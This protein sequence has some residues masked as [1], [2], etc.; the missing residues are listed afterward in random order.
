MILLSSMHPYNVNV[1]HMQV[2]YD[3]HDHNSSVW[4][5]S[6]VPLELGPRYQNLLI[7]YWSIRLRQSKHNH[8][9]RSTRRLIEYTIYQTRVNAATCMPVMP[10]S[11]GA[12]DP[13]YTVCW[14]FYSLLS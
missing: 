5:Y 10:V 11:Y 1:H 6:D 12:R 3:T 14:I 2:G 4:K 8:Y 7:I 9:L 13:Y